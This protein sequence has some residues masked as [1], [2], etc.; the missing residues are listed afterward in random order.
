M[1]FITIACWVTADKPG[2]LTWKALSIIAVIISA[3]LTFLHF[4]VKATVDKINAVTLSPDA[5]MFIIR[6]LKFIDPNQTGPRT[7]KI[8]KENIEKD[9]EL[10]SAVNYLLGFGDDLAIAINNGVIS[11]ALTKEMIGSFVVKIYKGLRPYIE[12]VDNYHTESKYPNLTEL[13]LRWIN[14]S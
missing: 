1:V 14:S 4:R 11:E 6:V 13:S 8:N 2:E 9:D 3:Y 12:A 5:S 7:Q 10:F